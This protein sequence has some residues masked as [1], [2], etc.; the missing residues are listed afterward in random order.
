MQDLG[1][2][3]EDLGFSPESGGSHGELQAEMSRSQMLTGSLWW[4]CVWG[5]S[6]R[7]RAEGIMLVQATGDGAGPR[8]L[9]GVHTLGV[10]KDR[11]DR[12]S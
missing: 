10:F 5:D 4:L 2:L 12:V 3:R 8:W 11:A 6:V 7:M 9:R 1:V